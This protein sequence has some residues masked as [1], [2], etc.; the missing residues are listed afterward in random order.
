MEEN[1]DHMALDGTTLRNLEILTNSVDYKVQGSLWHKINFTKTPHGARLLRA[2]LLRPLFRPSEIHRRAD[3]VQELVSGAAA[4]ALQEAST[5]LAQCGDIERLLSRVHSMSGK[6]CHDEGDD[7][8]TAGIHPNDRAIMYESAT[9]TQRKV[10]DFSRLLQGLRKASLIPEIFQ[11]IPID[12]GLLRKITSLTSEGGCFPDMTAEL[13]WFFQNFDCQMAAKGLF[14]PSR[15]IDES[16]DKA[17]EEIEDIL[18]SLEDYKREVC[19]ILRPVS[20]AKTTWKYINTKP[21]SKDKYLIELPANIHVPDDFI[22]KGKRGS[23]SKQVNKYRTKEVQD[24]VDKL[25]R[26]IDVQKDRKARGMQLIF[27]KFDA[28]RNLWAAAAQTTA[29]LDALGSLAHVASK[30]GYS[31][32]KILDCPADRS[33]VISIRQGRHPCVENTVGGLEFVPNDLLLGGSTAGG[34]DPR[35][36]LLSGPNMGGKSTLLRQTCL[37]AI[38]AQMGSFVPAEACELTPIDSIY[39]RLGASDRLLLGQSTFFVEVR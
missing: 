3:A 18:A 29:L 10:G 35:V 14:E 2:W 24:M 33:P 6:T 5:L 15:G 19:S 25:E 34:A 31:R 27:A 13:D 1:I 32:P 9:Y 39:T 28:S 22:I 26:A 4:V 8:A 30:P 21:D 17:C 36:L 23:G 37:I 11:G 38:L 20:L 12:S 7:D 16:Y